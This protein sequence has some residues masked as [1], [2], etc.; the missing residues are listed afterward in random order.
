MIWNLIWR[1]AKHL[2]LLKSWSY[3]HLKFPKY[4]PGG[5]EKDFEVT[6]SLVGLNCRHYRFIAIT[7]EPWGVRFF[8]ASLLQFRIEVFLQKLE[9]GSN[10]MQNFFGLS[11]STALPKTNLATSIGSEVLQSPFPWSLIRAVP[12]G[13]PLPTGLLTWNWY[14]RFVLWTW[15]N[16]W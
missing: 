13:T 14:S 2:D 6:I 1:L 10:N 15:R 9:G 11:K 7:S 16:K 5:D 3:G 12:T 4:C 8:F